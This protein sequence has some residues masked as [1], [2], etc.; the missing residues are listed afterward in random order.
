L[1]AAAWADV[2]GAL[3]LAD[4]NL[5]ALPAWQPLTLVVQHHM[6]S[7]CQRLREHCLVVWGAFLGAAWTT[8]PE[9][10]VDAWLACLKD[11]LAYS[12]TPEQK[13]SAL[14]SLQLAG[15][16]APVRTAVLL[17]LMHALQDEDA[18]VRSTA[19]DTVGR[20][21]SSA[22]P[23]VSNA[24]VLCFSALASADS[25]VSVDALT[26]LLTR[27]APTG[28]VRTVFG[29]AAGAPVALFDTEECNQYFE[30]IRQTHVALSA[31]LRLVSGDDSE[32]DFDV[33]GAGLQH[34]DVVSGIR[35]TA[36]VV[37]L[38]ATQA[39][40]WVAELARAWS[41][42]RSRVEMP[43][44]L[45]R[46]RSAETLFVYCATAA[47]LACIHALCVLHRA[48]APT[49]WQADLLAVQLVPG[50]LPLLAEAVEVQSALPPICRHLLYK[51]VQACYHCHPP[52]PGLE[53]RQAAFLSACLA[54]SIAVCAE[55]GES[56]VIAAGAVRAED[57]GRLLAVPVNPFPHTSL[58]LFTVGDPA[59]KFGGVLSSANAG[60]CDELDTA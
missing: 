53:T 27:I 21:L 40:L 16:A 4:S 6:T 39:G 32:P 9:E 54:A 43:E 49:E 23:A 35:A 28:S 33:P 18:E 47:L 42:L 57:V 34:A 8:T 37:T 26:Q 14:N 41:F 1:D 22:K 48:Q 10:T 51:L 2:A 13:T 7:P 46:L 50:L 60:G 58:W 38:L 15:L 24:L 19:A 36:P 20:L 56:A 11:A 25:D 59:G 3:L 44:A 5:V 17:L 31:F 29:G 52:G 45:L 55:G 30:P 12:A